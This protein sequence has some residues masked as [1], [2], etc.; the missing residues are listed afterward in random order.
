MKCRAP[1]IR[2]GTPAIAGMKN[3]I[4]IT[5]LFSLVVSGIRGFPWSEALNGQRWKKPAPSPGDKDFGG[6]GEAPHGGTTAPR[7]E[8]E[9]SLVSHLYIV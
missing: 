4:E 8:V 2:P 6:I 5:S 3:I 1:A 9:P 7:Q